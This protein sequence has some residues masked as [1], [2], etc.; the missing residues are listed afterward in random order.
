MLLHSE[1]HIH[2]TNQLR[3]IERFS[4]AATAALSSLSFDSSGPAEMLPL[5]CAKCTN[6]HRCLNVS[7]LAAL[8]ADDSAVSCSQ[9]VLY[10]LVLTLGFTTMSIC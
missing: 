10:N 2:R 6:Y 7:P 5:L 9:H 4:R 8:E 3:F 1:Y